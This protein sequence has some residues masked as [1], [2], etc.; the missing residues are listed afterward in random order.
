VP[1]L[2]YNLRL[3]YQGCQ[4][5]LVQHTKKGKIYHEIFHKKYQ[6]AIKYIKWPYNLPNSHKIYQMG[7]KYTKWPYNLPNGHKIYQMAL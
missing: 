5:F 4:I 6:M 1:F 7:I 2:E 3:W